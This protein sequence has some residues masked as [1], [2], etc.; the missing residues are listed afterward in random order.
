MS[1]AIRF[2]L[3]DQPVIYSGPTGL[4]VL[5]YLREQVRL[6]GTK[7]GCREGDCGACMVMIGVPELD[8]VMYR[9]APACLVPLAELHGK[10]LVTIEGLNQQSL[11]PVQQALVEEGAVQCGFCTPGIVISLVC[12]LLQVGSHVETAD[13]KNIL[14]GHLCRCTGYGAIKR[15]A[16]RLSALTAEKNSAADPCLPL[17]RAGVLPPYFQTIPD[18][19][20]RIEK[21][22]E[23]DAADVLVAGGTD[24]VVQKGESLQEENV[25]SLA[26]RGD[27]SDITQTA[28]GLMIGS[29]ITMEEFIHHPL[30]LS[31][32]PDM[33]EYGERIASWQVRSRATLAGNI[34][35]ASPIADMTILLI[36]LQAQVE[37]DDGENRRRLALADFFLGYKKLDRTAQE[38]LTRIFIPRVLPDTRIHFEKV[39]KRKHLDIASVNSAI[40]IREK[41]GIVREV[42]LSC[43]GVAP[44]PLLLRETGRALYSKPLHMDVLKKAVKVLDEEIKPIDDVRGSAKYKRLLARQLFLNHFLYLYP[45][46]FSVQEALWIC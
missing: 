15:A 35:N 24:L 32:I 46:I 27:L 3:N 6:T 36:A 45:E 23:A 4:T 28:N 9:P 41:N 10:H 12:H 7:E 18:H 42:A 21:R 19:L 13:I 8:R 30:I 16:A 17:I 22:V 37:L 25:G 34:I 1:L 43:G 44:V 39:A 5:A 26:Y 29:L 40:R 11:S 33:I 20:S 38:L 14:S 2:V 31:M